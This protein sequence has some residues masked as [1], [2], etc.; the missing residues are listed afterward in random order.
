MPSISTTN[1]VGLEWMALET[2]PTSTTVTAPIDGISIVNTTV[3]K[4]I[5]YHASTTVPTTANTALPVSTARETCTDNTSIDTQV[6]INISTFS[7]A[8]TF[9][10]ESTSPS[11]LPL[12]TAC[13]SSEVTANATDMGPTS[14]TT[15]IVTPATIPEASSTDNLRGF[16]GAVTST[17]GS[18]SS[19]S[20]DFHGVHVPAGMVA[21][22]AAC[23]AL[24]LLL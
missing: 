18:A 10:P 7:A 14:K 13:N 2:E 16:T 6:Y 12:F 23:F 15:N 24:A 11:S 19:K 9:A 22:M 17:L 1:A 5:T 8:Y 4:T 3:V 21:A 20:F